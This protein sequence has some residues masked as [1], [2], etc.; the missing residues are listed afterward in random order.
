M[1][2]FERE[3]PNGEK[4]FYTRNLG[5]DINVF[6]DGV[7]LSGD[8]MHFD[9]MNGEITLRNFLDK[10]YNSSGQPEFWENPREFV[11]STLKLWGKSESTKEES[12][13]K[14]VGSNKE[15]IVQELKQEKELRSFLGEPLIVVPSVYRVRK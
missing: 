13:G 1:T 10:R 3:L 9:E 11:I 12:F 15:L 5:N 6:G 8:L 7:M 2:G 14:I 4:D